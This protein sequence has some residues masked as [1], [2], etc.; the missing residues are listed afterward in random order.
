MKKSLFKRDLKA[1]S[2]LKLDSVDQHMARLEIL[3]PDGNLFTKKK[4]TIRTDAFPSD[5]E[6]AKYSFTGKIKMEIAIAEIPR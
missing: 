5:F 4:L 6:I 2:E 3:D 1:E